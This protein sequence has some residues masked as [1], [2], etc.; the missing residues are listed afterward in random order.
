MSPR[1][2]LW[3]QHEKGRLAGRVVFDEKGSECAFQRLLASAGGSSAWTIRRCYC[4]FE[5]LAG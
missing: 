3:T 4:Q 1:L 2:V 5:R